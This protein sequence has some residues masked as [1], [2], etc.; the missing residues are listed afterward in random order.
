MHYP[1]DKENMHKSIYDFSE[2]MTLAIT[3]GESITLN[4]SYSEIRNIVIAGMGGSAIGGDIIRA[5]VG[6][7]LKVPLVVSRHYELPAWVD[8]RSLVI[9]SSYSGNTEEILSA[10]EDAAKKGAQICGV[11]TGG[12]LLS[13]LNENLLDSVIIPDGL[14]PRAA[15]ALSFIPTLYLLHALGLIPDTFQEELLHAQSRLNKIREVFSIDNDEN[16]CYSLASKIYCTI[17]VIYGQTEWTSI[18]AIRFKG[19]LCE[20]GK[21]LAYHNELPEF[22]HNEIVGWENNSSL[23]N[24]ISVIWIHDEQDHPRVKLRQEITE[25]I[26]SELPSSQHIVKGEGD[27]AFERFLYIV[28]YADWVSYWCAIHHQTDPTPVIKIDHLKDELGKVK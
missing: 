17:P 18:A 13:L 14:Q 4:Q 20:N 26:L 28:H 8:E 2:H 11:T 12:R 1:I 10:Y 25:N 24:S 16:P 23:L 5:L 15:L 7:T 21:M 9:C 19:Q 3:I 22:N 27:S 6:S